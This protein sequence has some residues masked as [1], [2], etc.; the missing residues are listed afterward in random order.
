M[1]KKGWNEMDFHHRGRSVICFGFVV[2][3]G[4]ALPQLN[5]VLLTGF[6][7][8]MHRSLQRLL[9]QGMWKRMSWPGKHI[10]LH[11]LF[12]GAF[13]KFQSHLRVFL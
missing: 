9:H 4:L 3:M 12:N 8:S 7:I 11:C 6:S 10:L 1:G 13:P 5:L 2:L